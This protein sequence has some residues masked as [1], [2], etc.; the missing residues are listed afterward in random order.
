MVHPQEQT[1]PGRA[2][3]CS[4]GPWDS[5]RPTTYLGTGGAVLSGVD[6]FPPHLAT[7]HHPPPPPPEASWCSRKGKSY[8]CHLGCLPCSLL[9][10]RNLHPS[11][12]PRAQHSCPIVPDKWGWKRAAVA[13]TVPHWPSS[14]G[15][16]R[17]PQAHQD[18]CLLRLSRA[19]QD[20]YLPLFSFA[21]NM[22]PKTEIQC[23]HRHRGRWRA[24][25][26]CGQVSWSALRPALT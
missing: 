2:Q 14:F 24:D 15:E 6:F 1:R 20:Q 12:Q 11:S 18:C 3:P 26:P 22:S 21:E 25:F 7:A 23:P 13:P 10:L 9:S 5:R 19:K 17:T 16:G 8:V 4:T